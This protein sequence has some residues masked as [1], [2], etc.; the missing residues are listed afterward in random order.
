M[1]AKRRGKDFLCGNRT[2]SNLLNGYIMAKFNLNVELKNL[3]GKNLSIMSD[4][5]KDEDGNDVPAKEIPLTAANAVVKA[6][7]ADLP[8]NINDS[9]DAKNT[10]YQI[11][12]KVKDAEVAGEDVS[13]KSEE[14]TIVKDA[15]GKLWGVMTVGAVIDILEAE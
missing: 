11:A 3:E 1:A 8:S 6:L 12:K 9:A 15:V 14:V 7:T 10:K 2:L 13:L 4:P 5:S